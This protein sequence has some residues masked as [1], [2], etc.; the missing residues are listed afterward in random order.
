MYGNY[1]KST[2]QRS[3]DCYCFLYFMLGVVR[4]W[5]NM[6][7]SGCRAVSKDL[8]VGSNA[9]GNLLASAKGTHCKFPH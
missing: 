8:Y 2:S 9:H 3:V 5:S 4:I 6:G 1:G 7:E